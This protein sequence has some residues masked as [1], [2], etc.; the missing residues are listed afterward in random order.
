MSRQSR[1]FFR[2]VKQLHKW[3]T[4]KGRRRRLRVIWEVEQHV[5]RSDEE[6]P[7]PFGSLC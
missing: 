1:V 7:N 3:G 2:H 6:K 4:T 5:L